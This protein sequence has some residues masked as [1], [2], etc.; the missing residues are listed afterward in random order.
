[1]NVVSAEP[2][3]I[4]E[5]F[6]VDD[7]VSARMVMRPWWRAL[8]AD[9]DGAV[10]DLHHPAL[11][12]DP[13]PGLAARFRDELGVTVE[14]CATMG[15]VNTVSILADQTWAFF[16]KTGVRS[17]Y[18]RPILSRRSTAGDT[19]APAARGWLIGVRRSDDGSWRVSGLMSVD[20]T[21]GR[22]ILPPLIPGRATS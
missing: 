22:V 9:D 13:G 21:V 3:S 10:R 1:M 16:C 5:S 8:A 7:A 2:V 18:E 15:V 12:P 20:E 4:L 6:P 11:V 19:V 17:T 14:Q